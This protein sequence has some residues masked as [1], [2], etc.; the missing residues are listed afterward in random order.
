MGQAPIALVN[1]TCVIV[2]WDLQ[3]AARHFVAI[4]T[5]LASESTC[6]GDKRLKLVSFPCKFV[7]FPGFVP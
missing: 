5:V 1:R 4:T 6:R 2:V 3:M 7:Y